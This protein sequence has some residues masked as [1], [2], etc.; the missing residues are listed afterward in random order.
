MRLS[1]GGEDASVY[2]NNTHHRKA[3]NGQQRY[4]ADTADATNGTFALRYI[5]SN[6][7]TDIVRMPGIEHADGDIFC[8]NGVDCRRIHH[9]RTEIAKLGCLLIGEFRYSVGCGNE[10][11]VGRH[12]SI[13]I[14]PYL[15]HL[16]IELGRQDCCRIIRSATTEVGDFTGEAVSSNKAW[17]YHHMFAFFESLLHELRRQIRAE[18]VGVASLRFD[19]R[20]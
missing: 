15:K 8:T 2:T 20:T 1:Q 4:V 6:H 5:G 16:S 11:R 14:C 13:Y 18:R 12:E 10:S 9:F 7:S 17:T 19:E 3:R